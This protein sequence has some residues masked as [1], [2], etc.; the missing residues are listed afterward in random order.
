M[1]IDKMWALTL[2]VVGI[3]AF[4]MAVT[5]IIDIEIPDAIVRIVGVIG[6]VAIPVL[7]YTTI[8]K[9]QTYKK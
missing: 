4:I 1:K 9:F 3:C 7:I 8:K 5:N 2:L 6:L